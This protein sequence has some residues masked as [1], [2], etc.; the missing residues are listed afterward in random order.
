M[1]L[2]MGLCLTLSL[3][4]AN[5]TGAETIRLSKPV[6]QSD[7]SETFGKILDNNLMNV[8]MADIATRSEALLGKP[9]KV[10]TKIAKVCQKKGCFFIAQYQEHVI[11]VSFRDYG[12]FIPTDA[13]GKTV[14]LAGELIKKEVTP[15]QAAHFKKD[16]NAD[17]D[18]VKTGVV[19]EIVAD[20]VVIPRVAHT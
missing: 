15:E 13:G 12:F 7:T 14:V 4:M 16:L 5:A 10:E 11:R 19:Y 3:V 20:S 6:A 8:S 9:F 2:I 17:S 1:K 18:A